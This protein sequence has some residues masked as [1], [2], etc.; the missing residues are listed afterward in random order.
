MVA[1]KVPDRSP[2]F[3][4]LQTHADGNVIKKINEN[5]DHD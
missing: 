5:E 3:I 1:C 2:N 4:N